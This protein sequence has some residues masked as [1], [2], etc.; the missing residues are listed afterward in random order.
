MKTELVATIGNHP[1]PVLSHVERKVHCSRVHMDFAREVEL[2]LVIKHY[3]NGVYIPNDVKDRTATIKAERS[4]FRNTQGE[5][6]PRVIH[7][8][9]Y[10]EY[11]VL[12]EPLIENPDF[13]TAI[14]SIN[15]FEAGFNAYISQDPSFERALEYIFQQEISV[16]ESQG[17]F[18]QKLYIQ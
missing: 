13:A 1:S 17:R 14:D 9:Y 12:S 2:E 8:P 15:F 7:N 5:V 18:G 6:I 16:H 4:V 3:H 11:N 10:D